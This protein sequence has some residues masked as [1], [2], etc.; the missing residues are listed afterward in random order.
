MKVIIIVHT[1][2]L[3]VGKLELASRVCGCAGG[4]AGYGSPA[5]ER[6]HAMKLFPDRFCLGGDLVGGSRT[7]YTLVYPK[8]H[9]L[10]MVYMRGVSLPVQQF[11]RRLWFC[12]IYGGLHS[13]SRVPTIQIPCSPGIPDD[14]TGAETTCSKVISTMY[15]WAR[16]YE[17]V[18]TKATKSGWLLRMIQ[19]PLD[20]FYI[21]FCFFAM[22]WGRH[23]AVWNSGPARS[24]RPR[25][26]K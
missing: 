22:E 3:L 18:E 21:F 12:F 1:G 8:H 5:H 13:I 16:E 7:V 6:L 25:R 26:S 9:V 10:F 19:L 20:A 23:R 14:L 2:F 15:R 4:T 24:L 17:G 11:A